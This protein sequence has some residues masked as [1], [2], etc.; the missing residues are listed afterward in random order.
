MNSPAF[1]VGKMVQRL[2]YNLGRVQKEAGLRKSH[3]PY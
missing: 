1:V 2:S 3:P